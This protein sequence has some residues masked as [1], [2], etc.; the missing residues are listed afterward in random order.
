MEHHPNFWNTTPSSREDSG[1]TF[2]NT[3][4]TF[5][6]PPHRAVGLEQL[7]GAPPQLL[8]HH[9]IEPWGFWD[10]FLEHQPNTT[11]S[12]QQREHQPARV[13]VLV[14]L[15]GTPPPSS[16]RATNQTA[17]NTIYGEGSGA[18]FGTPPHRAA[19][20]RPRVWGLR[21][22]FSMRAD[23]VAARINHMCQLGQSGCSGPLFDGDTEPQQCLVLQPLLSP[24]VFFTLFSVAWVPPTMVVPT[25]TSL[26]SQF[27]A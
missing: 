25:L 21:D 26:R 4:P 20:P 24:A 18:T 23:Q 12:A 10:N 6:T 17:R 15:F 8:E 9:P 27:C 1:T 11:P 14:Q 2:W 3:T 19:G 16:R 5:G 13:G 7:F 22:Y